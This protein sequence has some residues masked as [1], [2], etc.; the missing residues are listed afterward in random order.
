MTATAF[1]MPVQGEI[2]HSGTDPV[3]QRD[4]QIL[5]D[6][7]AGLFQFPQLKSIVWEQYTPY[8][9]DG[10]VCE[11]SVHGYSLRTS[12]HDAEPGDDDYYGDGFFRI[13]DGD[14]LEYDYDYDNTTNTARGYRRATRTNIRIGTDVVS[15]LL[16]ED[17]DNFAALLNSLYEEL[18]SGGHDVFLRATFGDH[19]E[20]TATVD[21]FSIDYFSHD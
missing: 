14:L 6:L 1:G 18:D 8:F 9:N 16:G 21:G 13:E 2:R 20:V 7:F 4:P 15:A 12:F 17:G 19:A 11:F 10:D 3:D 5:G